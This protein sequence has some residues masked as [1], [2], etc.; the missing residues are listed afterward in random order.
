[1]EYDLDSV[2]FNI[3]TVIV[4]RLK[5]PEW[6]VAIGTLT[7]ALATFYSVHQF[8]R[9]ELR[10]IN[11][12]TS[13]KVINPLYMDLRKI[14]SCLERLS[15]PSSFERRHGKYVEEGYPL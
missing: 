14:E 2:I 7:L 1:M 4:D 11:A 6:W 12:D 9:S 3:L 15:L 13:E 10:R 5:E 8:K